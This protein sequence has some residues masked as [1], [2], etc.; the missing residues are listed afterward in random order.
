MSKR[1]CKSCGETFDPENQTIEMSG[2]PDD[3]ADEA[4]DQVMLGTKCAECIVTDL[5]YA[6][7]TMADLY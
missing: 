6:E 5:A 7:S 4:F 3:F 1:K 2:V